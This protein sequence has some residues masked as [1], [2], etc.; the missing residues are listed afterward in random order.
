MFITTTNGWSSRAILTSSMKAL[1]I[2]DISTSNPRYNRLVGWRAIRSRLEQTVVT[3][4]EEID[5]ERLPIVDTTVV[6]AF[7][8]DHVESGSN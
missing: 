4:K 3:E 1:P 8:R 6:A 7:P 5:Y 2:S